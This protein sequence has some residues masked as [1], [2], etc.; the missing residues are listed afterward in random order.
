MNN[1]EEKSEVT[2]VSRYKK[3]GMIA[4]A[5]FLVVLVFTAA[6]CTGGG[7]ADIIENTAAPTSAPDGSDII[8]TVPDGDDIM[9]EPG[10]IQDNSAKSNKAEAKEDDIDI[11]VSNN[12]K[13]V[14]MTVETTGRKNPFVP[15]GEIKESS[16]SNN[17]ADLQK[18]KLKYDLVDPPNTADADS[19]AQRVLTTKVSGVMYDPQSPSAILN[20]EGS[21]FLVRSGDVV[22]GYKVLAI[23]PTVVTVQ[24]G[25]NVYKAGV[26]ELLATDGIQYNTISNLSSK[27]GGAK[28]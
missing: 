15:A 10:S 2:G 7:N 25:A 28:K 6:G 12:E 23:S 24:L 13:M 9:V 4:A 26:G 8:N 1:S 19:D 18:A 21:D 22:N 3:A 14:A 27:F 17:L 5:I 11:I 20:I 16:N